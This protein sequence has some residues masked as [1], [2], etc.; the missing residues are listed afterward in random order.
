MKNVTTA[1]HLHTAN[2]PPDPND[3]KKR[4]LIPAG[5]Y[6][7]S[8]D[9]CKSVR[10]RLPTWVSRP[11]NRRERNMGRRFAEHTGLNRRTRLAIANRERN[12]AV[13]VPLD[14]LTG[15]KSLEAFVK[16]VENENAP[17]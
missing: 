15:Q 6:V 5:W 8:K 11:K 17:R 1:L 7:L 3:K 2:L 10:L 13:R 12:V 16:A 9:E 4:S 14:Y